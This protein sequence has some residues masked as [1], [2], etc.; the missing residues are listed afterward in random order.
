MKTLRFIGM[1]LFAILMCTSFIACSEE[2]DDPIGPTPTP[3]VPK[4]E[5][6]IDANLITNGLSFSSVQGEQSISFSTNEDWTVNVANTTSGATWCTASATS[7]TKG[8]ASVKFAV[9]ENTD[10]EDRSVS[11]TIKAG[12]ASKTFTI[13]QKSADALL[14]TTDKYEVSQE[15]GT[16][17]IE[18][19][20]NIDYKMEISEKAKDWIKES[21]LR[22]MTTYK[23]TLEIAVNQDAEKREGEI[24]FKSDD[25]VETV[26][27]Y[28]AGGAIILL[29]QN[30]YNVSDKGETISVEVKSN[31]DFDVQMPDVDWIIDDASLRGLSSHTLK[32]IIA[33]NETN[34]PR[35]AEIIF[36]DKN[37][38]L[39][40]TLSIK[41]NGGFLVIGKNL[42]MHPEG[43][44]L[45]Y[46]GVADLQ[47]FLYGNYEQK[48]CKDI[49]SKFEDAFD[50]IFFLY[51]TSGEDFTLGGTAYPVKMDIEGIGMNKINSSAL[52]GSKGYLKSVNHLTLRTSLFSA[53]PFLHELAH[54]WGAVDIG[55]E[56][57]LVDGSYRESIHWGTSDIDGILGG[58][59]YQTLKR[60]VDGNPQKYWAT[61]T[62][63]QEWGFDGFSQELSN[64]YFAPIELYL[65]GLLPA[66]SVPD[67]HVFHD[68]TLEQETWGDGTFYA[69]SEST[70]TMDDFIKKYGK[71]KP[72]Y[73]DSQ[74]DFRALVVVVT[75]Q[76]V[77]DEHWALIKEDMLKQEKQG[78]VND[79][80]QT[81]FWEATGGR[82]TLSLSGID[83]FLK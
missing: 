51:N 44:A 55:Q 6:I 2:G 32:Y 62:R 46:T 9:T 36:F 19:K 49:Y 80:R 37:S 27:V 31:V 33:R 4:S 13:A 16:I 17:E 41:Q 29:S 77:S 83:K 10:Y 12:T 25:L 30:E 18:V 1:A 52:Y 70:I 73:K 74:K 61:S 76:P 66:E 72:D 82:A 43:F 5:I 60:N 24:T 69:K 3:E 81:N 42:S 67:M 75:D 22:A 59:N 65:M 14:V 71:R 35:E 7:G 8:S 64:G 58:F 21:S 45:Q 11:V 15:G 47:D 54:Y 20:A 68:V 56:Y 34:K 40:D 26:K 28:Q 50:F 53:G 38:D 57:A 63:A 79:K 78:A 39:K 48:I 23:H